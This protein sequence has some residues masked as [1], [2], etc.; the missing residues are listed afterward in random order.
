MDTQRHVRLGR[1]GE[2][3]PQGGRTMLTPNEN[4]ARTLGVAPLS[5]E[6]LARQVLGE[7][8]I[9][10]PLL[11]HNL[12]REAME[13]TLGSSD[14][15]GVARSLY[16]SIREL[17]RAGAD[18]EMD[19][20]SP[21][22]RRV[23]GVAHAYRER[24]RARGLIDPAETLWE[25]TL[26]SPPPRPVLVWG[27]PRMGPGEVAF[28]DAVAGEGSAV[29]FPY[30]EDPLFA[31]NLQTARD[32]EEREWTVERNPLSGVW[33]VGK[34]TEAHS[35]PHTEA[36]VRGALTRVK[37]LLADGVRP[38]EIVL[39]ARDDA[40]YGPT[41]LSVAQEYGVPVRALYRV[42]VSETRVG[43]WLGLLFEAMVEGFPFES[44]VR[45]LAHPLGPGIPAGRWARARR[46][47]PRGT[48]AWEELEVDLSPLAW[49]EADTRAGWVSRFNAL[50]QAY[51]LNKKTLS[52]PRETIALARAKDEVGWLAEPADE[53][54]TR[55]RFV[56]E[57]DEV[58][59]ATDTPAHPEREG[60]ALHTPLSLYGAR[61]RFVFAM[62]LTEGG[63]PPSTSDDPA[64][65][66]HERKRLREL[67]VRL[68]LAHERA[69]RERLSFWALLRV[70]Q[71]RLVLSYPK[72]ANGREALPSPY[73][74]LVGAEPAAPGELP[75]ASPE[76]ARRAYLQ[77]G[78]LEGDPVLVRAERSWQVERRREGPEPFDR[79]DGVLGVPVAH[80]GRSFSVS[81]LGDLVHCGFRWW[82]RSVLGLSEPEEGEPPALVGR[83]YHKALEVAVRRAEGAPDLRGGVLEHLEVAFEE[84]EGELEMASRAR[85]WEAW[86][87]VY[88][89]QLR[90]A[91]ESE[92]FALPGAEA[93][94]TEV[95]FSGEWRGFEVVGRVDRID[96][97][98]EGLVFVD[99]KSTSSAPKPDLQ[100]SV[101]KEA[102]APALFPSE[103][104]RDA[105]YYSL[106]RA[107][108]IRARE[109][110]A[111][112]LASMAEEVRENLDAGNLPPDVLQRVCAFCEYD[113]VCRRGPR[114]DRKGTE[115]E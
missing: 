8:R 55:E 7:E 25:A 5:V 61:Y 110:D 11:A 93:V 77:R 47:R 75:A 64:L 27:Y 105:Y 16:P 107:E 4:A 32:F 99:Y 102:A 88:L 98:P 59:R 109:P 57:V 42:P 60:V 89:A 34:P 24:L 84:A 58:L 113:L 3:Y 29:H 108:R 101:Y 90:R 54:I 6:T 94:E 53:R 62:G 68:E 19:S 85:A 40:G 73:F 111:G 20:G 115:G 1:W 91:V 23:F 87:G 36:E 37:V 10:H 18:T 51:A 114:L 45:F 104:V 2:A 96:R 71:E 41:V 66:F 50:V 76:E 52:W 31:D 100:L 67:G 15:A 65:D 14:S 74:G 33:E 95:T 35:Y 28:V 22:A 30:A 17:F 92:D 80:Q 81:E 63:F 69:R 21:R 97:T 83:L 48:T 79:F 70:P 38:D 112:A 13:E 49:P 72:L 43:Y 9:A 82:S 39:V 106:R 56:G 78:G 86:R 103:P 12:L 46:V 26:S 44:T